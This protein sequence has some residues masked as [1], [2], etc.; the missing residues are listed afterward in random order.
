[1]V[2]F[3]WMGVFVQKKK[4]KKKEK[5]NGDKRERERI[6]EEKKLV[7]PKRVQMKNPHEGIWV[8]S[9]GTPLSA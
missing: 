5:R 9:K 7:Q 3:F 6:T 2:Q 8:I 4:K 1:M